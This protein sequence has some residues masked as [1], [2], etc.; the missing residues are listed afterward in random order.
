MKVIFLFVM[1]W[2]LRL[3][4]V[5]LSCFKALF[6]IFSSYIFIYEI[7]SNLIQYQEIK[8]F[9]SQHLFYSGIKPAT[10]RVK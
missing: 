1:K 6:C 5:D 4:L 2:P 8:S 9:Q 7:N 3:Y 10:R